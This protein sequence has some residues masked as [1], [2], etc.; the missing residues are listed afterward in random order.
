MKN[1]LILTAV[2]LLA[3]AWLALD[4]AITAMTLLS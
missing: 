1:D 3:T 2:I 4:V